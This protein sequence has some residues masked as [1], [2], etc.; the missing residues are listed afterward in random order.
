MFQRR[1][2][3]QRWGGDGML[4]VA[5]A[6]GAHDLLAVAASEHSHSGYGT[7]QYAVERRPSVSLQVT[8]SDLLVGFEEHVLEE[9]SNEG[10]LY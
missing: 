10:C 8:T 7:T 4:A 9:Q 3:Q 1:H 6:P 5:V 2:M